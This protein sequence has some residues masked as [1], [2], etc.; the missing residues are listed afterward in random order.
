MSVGFLDVSFPPLILKG[1]FS[2][3]ES[4]LCCWLVDKKTGE[5]KRY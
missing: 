3:H 1:D 2:T 4:A 5:E